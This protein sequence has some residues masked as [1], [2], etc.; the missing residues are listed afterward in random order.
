MPISYTEISKPSGP[1]Y[2]TISKPTSFSE[3]FLFQDGIDFLFQDSI[4]FLIGIGVASM[5]TGISKPSTPTYL[6]VNKPS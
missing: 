5:Y 1:T 2:S 3:Q 4:E 6:T